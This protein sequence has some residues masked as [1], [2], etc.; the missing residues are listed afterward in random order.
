VRA[1]LI[2]EGEEW[3]YTIDASD[4]NSRPE[5]SISRTPGD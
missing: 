1:G 2:A 4:L 3:P 5:A